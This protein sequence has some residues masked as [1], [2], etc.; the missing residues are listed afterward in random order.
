MGLIQKKDQKD[1]IDGIEI[2]ERSDTPNDLPENDVELVAGTSAEHI[3]AGTTAEE[4]AERAEAEMVESAADENLMPEDS[5][6]DAD[7]VAED[8]SD[9]AKDAEVAKPRTADEILADIK[10]KRT[11][12]CAVAAALV[13]IAAIAGYFVGNGG[14][15]GK[16]TGTAALSEDQLEATVASYS[17]NGKSVNVTAREAIESQYSVDNVK[18]DDGNYTAPSAETIL[19]YVRNRILIEQAEKEGVTVSAKE[20]KKVAKTAIGTSNYKTMAKQYG[21]TVKQAKKQVKEYALQQKLYKKVVKNSNLTAPT[22]PTE[23]ADENNLTDDEKATYAQ[24]IIE[25]AGKKWNS[26]KNTWKS[27][28]STYAQ[29]VGDFDGQTATYEQAQSAYYVAY[30]EYSTKASSASSEW[31][32]YENEL[33]ANA[34]IHVYGLFA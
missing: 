34:N 10:R 7:E 17:Y 1:E 30:Q 33:F 22:A 8:G 24:Y 23:P 21:L 25:L 9:D 16:G 3:A 13:I 26:K 12:F 5:E 31:T 19:S 6:D 27:S 32:N 29:Q 4:E 11:V 14:F 15:G 28:K 18:D 20:M 2:I